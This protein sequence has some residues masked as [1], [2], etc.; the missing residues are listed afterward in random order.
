[1]ENK[2]VKQVKMIGVV[3][4][5]LM[6]LFGQ[7]LG[8]ASFSKPSG[9]LVNGFRVL[10][11]NLSGESLEWT[12]FRGDY[13]KINIGDLKDPVLSIAPLSIEES[14]VSDL[15]QAPYFKMKKI[16]KFD[17][18]I[19]SLVGTLKVV[20]YNQVH[21][22]A[23][24]AQQAQQVIASF[25]P[26]ILDVRT[27][28]EFARGHLE[29]SVLMPVQQLQSRMDELAGFS[30]EPILIYCATGNRSTVASKLLIDKGF[31]R[32]FNMRHGISDWARNKYPIVK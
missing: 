4:G 16:G 1:M 32:I 20:E 29:N 27:P 14:L 23:V 6:V 30:D 12:V 3:L 21:Y 28:R 22:E 25:N 5:S 17:F 15:A 18:F 11:V 31:T 8:A 9:Q 24:S 26:I 19:G 7:T 2:M 13:I 10:S